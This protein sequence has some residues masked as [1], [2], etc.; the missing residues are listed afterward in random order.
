[1]LV[2]GP[3]G[4]IEIPRTE[5]LESRVLNKE[6]AGDKIAIFYDEDSDAARAFNS[7]LVVAPA[8]EFELRGLQFA[9]LRQD[10]GWNI[11][12]GGAEGENNPARR[13]Q[14]LLVIELPEPLKAIRKPVSGGAT[15]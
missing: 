2:I 10:I 12:N 4:E 9:P 11:H 14:P 15:Q 7:L 5:L 13:L 6:L 1:L 3:K 8:L